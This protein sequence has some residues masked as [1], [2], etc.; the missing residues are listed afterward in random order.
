MSRAGATTGQ[1]LP[2][3][4]RFVTTPEWHETVE[5]RLRDWCE[6]AG[7]ELRRVSVQIT[8]WTATIYSDAHEWL[9]LAGID[10]R[11]VFPRGSGTVEVYVSGELPEELAAAAGGDPGG[12]RAVGVVELAGGRCWIGGVADYRGVRR[13]VFE[14]LTG[15]ILIGKGRT[16]GRDTGRWLGMPAAALEWARVPGRARG[17]AFVGPHRLRT[18]HAFLLAR[19]AEGT[20]LAAIDWCFFRPKQRR[21]LAG[22]GHFLVPGRFLYWFPRLRPTLALAEPAVPVDAAARRRLLALQ[23]TDEMGDENAGDTAASQELEELLQTLGADDHWL[24]VSPDEL[25]GSDRLADSA[26]VLTWVVFPASVE[27]DSGADAGWLVRTGDRNELR[28]AIL[29]ECFAYHWPHA[30][31]AA[32]GLIDQLTSTKGVRVFVAHPDAHPAVL[33]LLLRFA[34]SGR[35]RAARFIEQLPDETCAKHL[36]LSRALGS[37]L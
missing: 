3:L 31:G 35:I 11:P 7:P 23:L 37:G 30:R 20:A 29:S 28:Q 36:Q 24:L 18:L 22:D 14:A 9:R 8:Q 4:L 27:R 16:A 6:R 17:I 1:W 13:A 12:Q 25:V 33:Q 21:A 5:G 2:P 34:V 10:W 26:S 15:R 32:E 19:Y